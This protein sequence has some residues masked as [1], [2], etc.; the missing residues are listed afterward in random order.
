MLS[1]MLL[2]Y[3]LAIAVG[4]AAS[5]RAQATNG[6]AEAR[7]ASTQPSLKQEYSALLKE[8]I[9][10]NS[11]GMDAWTM[12]S[13]HLFAGMGEMRDRVINFANRRGALDF[14]FG[15]LLDE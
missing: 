8:I 7:A 11:E 14:L 12:N 10:Y 9:Q 15:R 2:N 5:D 3:V 6:A 1:R 4:S 13:E